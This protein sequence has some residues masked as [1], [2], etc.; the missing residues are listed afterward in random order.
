MG[1]V[2]KGMLVINRLN[3]MRLDASPSNRLFDEIY[4]E[5]LQSVKIQPK[6]TNVS[7]EVESEELLENAT[8]TELLNEYLHAELQSLKRQINFSENLVTLIETELSSADDA[9]M[10][11]ADKY[12]VIEELLPKNIVGLLEVSIEGGSGYTSLLQKTYDNFNRIYDALKSAYAS[13]LELSVK[14]KNSQDSVS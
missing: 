12:R 13:Y 10:F 2:L 14:V 5:E 7:V 6:L 3:K 8:A 1:A 9:Q 4:A 11:R